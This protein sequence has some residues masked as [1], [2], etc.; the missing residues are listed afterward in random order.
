MVTLRNLKVNLNF[1]VSTALLHR[2]KPK[3]RR[4]N[5]VTTT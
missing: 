3:A 5:S 1:Q 2:S 4:E